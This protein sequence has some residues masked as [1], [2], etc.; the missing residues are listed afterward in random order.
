[1]SI[2]YDNRIIHHEKTVKKNLFLQVFRIYE[3]QI[4]IDAKP[5]LFLFSTPQSIQTLEPWVKDPNF[6]VFL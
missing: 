2:P 1:M 6:I 5:L 4:F 3:D